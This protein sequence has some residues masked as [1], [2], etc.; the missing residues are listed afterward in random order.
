MEARGGGGGQEVGNQEATSSAC[1]CLCLLDPHCV[2]A[3]NIK[4][5]PRHHNHK[6]TR[7]L[8]RTTNPQEDW[9]SKD[10]GV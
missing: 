5:L 6:L 7:K 9:G 2:H 1:L 4:A 3:Q 10:V 8:T